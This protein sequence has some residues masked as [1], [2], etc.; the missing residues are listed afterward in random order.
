MLLLLVFSEKEKN[1]L[2][3]CVQNEES[4]K[5]VIEI[6]RLFIAKI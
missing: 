6:F 1:F 3:K 4:R 5:K 2:K